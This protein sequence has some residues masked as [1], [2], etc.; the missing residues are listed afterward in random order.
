MLRTVVTIPVSAV[1]GMPSA[2]RQQ[3]VGTPARICDII[4][5]VGIAPDF[6]E[7]PA[8]RVTA[9]QY[10]AL[11]GVLVDELDDECLGFLSRPLRRGS[12]TMILRSAMGSHTV[13]GALNRIARAVS[14]LQDDLLVTCR[15]EVRLIGLAFERRKDAAA[16]MPL[17]H[18]FLLRVCWQL[19]DWLQGSGP[20]PRGFDFSFELPTGLAN[21]PS[22]Y[23]RN[24]PG[25]Q[26]FGQPWT[27]VWFDSAELARPPRN[28]ERAQHVGQQP[29]AP[30]GLRADVI[31]DDQGRAAPGH[32]SRI[33]PDQPCF[34]R[35]AGQRA[36]LRRYG[37]VPAGVQD[38]D[39]RRAGPVPAAAPAASARDLEHIVSASRPPLRLNVL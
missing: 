1:I 27:A 31:P 29:A 26:R 25:A 39:R 6:L 32:G 10:V 28:C 20:R 33:A 3:W 30:F 12:L 14:L 19:A 23:E 4:Q 38:M 37:S 17:G 34:A 9:L 15:R 21:D 13:E 36:W 2:V 24:F 16:V 8:A 7:D 22:V 18:E 35:G 11:Y 5:R